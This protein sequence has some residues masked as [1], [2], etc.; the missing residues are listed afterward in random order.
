MKIHKL[1]IVSS[2]F[3]APVALHPTLIECGSEI[4]LVDCGYPGSLELIEAQ[5]M[6]HGLTIKDLT[7]VIVTHDD[8]DHVGGLFELQ[9]A[10]PNLKVAASSTEAP[11]IEGKLKSLR[12]VQAEQAVD[13]LPGEMIDWAL[14]FQRELR[15]IKR[16]P[17]DQHLSEGQFN[18][19]IQ[20]VN[21]PGH[22]PGHISL[23]IPSRRT[24]IVGDAM[25]FENDELE[26][27]NP[28]FTLNLQAAIESVKKLTDF[29]IDEL[30]CYHGGVLT[31]SVN[32]KIAGLVDRYTQSELKPEMSIG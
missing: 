7:T 21:T 25:V 13:K 18:D 4:I 14:T 15:A 23:Y 11:F 3:G 31:G 28:D 16:V 2:P 20:V 26:I 19:L 30:H 5:L 17:V 29:E 22:T 8:I 24:M 27:A 12:L 1:D 9:R 10:N 6:L 32:E